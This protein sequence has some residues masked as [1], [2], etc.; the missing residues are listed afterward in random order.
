[1]EREVHHGD[2]E[3]DTSRVASELGQF[4]DTS[5]THDTT[6]ST[7]AAPQAVGE[8]T[9]HHVHETVQPVIHKETIQPEV[10]HTTIPIH[11]KHIAPSEHHGI[12]QLPTKTMDE[13]KQMGLNLGSGG[14]SSR[15]EY[16]GHPR[17][18]S[19]DLQLE[20]APADIEPRKHDG[21]HDPEATGHR[22]WLGGVGGKPLA[23]SGTTGSSTERGLIGA[24][25]AAPVHQ[26]HDEHHGAGTL[27][28]GALGG[29]AAGSAVGGLSNE[30]NINRSAGN[31]N[32]GSTGSTGTP[33]GQ[34]LDGNTGT[35]NTAGRDAGLAGVGG[36]G[37]AAGAAGSNLTDH[38]RTTTGQTGT[39][40]TSSV[41]DE[42]AK[43][44]GHRRTASGAYTNAD[45]NPSYGKTAGGYLTG[46]DGR[47]GP[48]DSSSTSTTTQAA[49]GAAAGAATGAAAHETSKHESPATQ[50]GSAENSG[51]R[52]F[53]DEKDVQHA[54][55]LGEDPS[56]ETAKGGKLTGTGADGSHSAVFGLTPGM[57]THLRS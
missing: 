55:K 47:H 48:Q 23:E 26:S 13:V 27:A 3:A 7:Q 32:S 21:T 17:P 49:E 34:G 45:Q 35:A 22:E 24:S 42:L 31:Y 11:E 29:A 50:Q 46:A 51:K 12:S 41:H 52:D 28:G 56:L 1:M 14:H 15:E 43:L 16:E 54:S 19:A 6:H 30:H 25:G 53:G 40:N 8:H 10:V 38:D 44:P 33:L 39:S 9:H 20:R 37:A 5:V 36:A 57:F 18:Y 4:K 2:R